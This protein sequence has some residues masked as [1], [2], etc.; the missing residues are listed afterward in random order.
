[1]RTARL[2]RVDY[3]LFLAEYIS[4]QALR[5]N[6]RVRFSPR[7]TLACIYFLQQNKNFHAADYLP[8][9][10]E[11]QRAKKN[12][13]RLLSLAHAEVEFQ[14]LSPESRIGLTPH[15]MDMPF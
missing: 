7:A 13:L 14:R 15:T 8:I 5:E 12:H 6:I 10:S 2:L 4:E 3:K 11:R 9:L 1:M